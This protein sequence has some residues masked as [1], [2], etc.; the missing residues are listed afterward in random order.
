VVES[1]FAAVRELFWPAIRDD[2]GALNGAARLAAPVF[3]DEPPSHDRAR[4]ASVLHG[5]YG[6]MDELAQRNPVV[7]LI[8]DAH[9]LDPAS[10]RFVAYMA[11]RIN[12]LSALIVIAP[13]SGEGSASSDANLASANLTKNVI[14]P[15]ALSAQASGAVVRNVLGPRADEEFCESLLHRYQGQPVLSARTGGRDP[16]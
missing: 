15:A 16:Q 1:S 8:D 10:A 14:R 9:W 6:L 7:L 3:E 2:P 12:S 13:R 11:P 4:V 5:L